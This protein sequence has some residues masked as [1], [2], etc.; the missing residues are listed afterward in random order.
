MPSLFS[1]RLANPPSS[2]LALFVLNQRTIPPFLLCPYQRSYCLEIYSPPCWLSV[3]LFK[4]LHDKV[5]RLLITICTFLWAYASHLLRQSQDLF[6]FLT[7]PVTVTNAFVPCSRV[8]AHP[9]TCSSAC[10]VL[11]SHGQTGDLVVILQCPAE[12]STPAWSL[13]GNESRNS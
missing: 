5:V 1:V 13:S 6:T 8:L 2:F 3:N 4:F 10:G 9:H 11:L 12:M 7:K